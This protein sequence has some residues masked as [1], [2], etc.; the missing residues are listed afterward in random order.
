M[1]GFIDFGTNPLSAVSAAS[2]ADQGYRWIRPRRTPIRWRRTP[3]AREPPARGAPDRCPS[4]P[5]E[6]VR[7]TQMKAAGEELSRRF[8]VMEAQGIEPWSE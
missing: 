3:H 4:A 7:D 5:D 8:Q 2:L 6:G 1:T